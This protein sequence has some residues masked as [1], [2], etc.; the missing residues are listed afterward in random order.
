MSVLEDTMATNAQDAYLESRILSADP[1]ELVEIL[2]QTAYRAVEKARQC[3]RR[4]DIAGR[5]KEI[6]RAI[7]T[8]AELASALD[9]QAAGELGLNLAQ[10][11]DYIQRRLIEAHIQQAEPPLA[12]VSQLLATLL[13][14]WSAVCR[15][16]E[17]AW[18]PAPPPA[19]ELEYASQTWSA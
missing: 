4:G 6:N 16:P 5:T 13:E 7:G 12:E 9:R 10:L 11:Y 1:L 3:L 15:K 17:P 18:T 2:Y 19:A 14:G 8:L